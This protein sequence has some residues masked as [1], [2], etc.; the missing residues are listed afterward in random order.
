VKPREA[1]TERRPWPPTR[2]W[3]VLSACVPCVRRV[4]RSP[5]QHGAC[6][7]AAPARDDESDER[8]VAA[9]D[10]SVEA[11]LARAVADDAR[12]ERRSGARRHNSHDATQKNETSMRRFNAAARC[13]DRRRSVRK[14]TA[15]RSCEYAIFSPSTALRA[16]CGACIGSS[17]RVRSRIRRLMPVGMGCASWRRLIGYVGRPSQ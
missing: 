11:V 14:C 4:R 6:R 12:A 5:G 1:A 17:T 13:H 8:R 16:R 2:A 9:A 7:V 15:A 3:R 10:G